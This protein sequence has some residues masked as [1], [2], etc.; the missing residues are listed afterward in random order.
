[1]RLF[2][3]EEFLADGN[4][5]LLRQVRRFRSGKKQTIEKTPLG[6]RAGSSLNSNLNE[7]ELLLKQNAIRLRNFD[8]GRSSRHA[9]DIEDELALGLSKRSGSWNSP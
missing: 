2:H 1:V 7:E 5:C 6:A 3:R 4:E 9:E 8:D